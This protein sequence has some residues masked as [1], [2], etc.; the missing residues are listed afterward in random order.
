MADTN[1]LMKY[2]G[3]I[4]EAIATRPQK[5]WTQPMEIENMRLNRDRIGEATKNLDDILKLRETSG[6]SLANAL[7]NIPQQQGYGTWLTDFARAFGGGMAAPMEARAQRA[8]KKH[9]ADL[10]DLLMTLNYDKAMG[11]Y[12]GYDN[13]PYA[14]GRGTGTGEQI[15]PKVYDF[16]DAPLPEKPVSWSELDVQ[17]YNRINPET[18]VRTPM[19]AVL[20]YM[21]ERLNPQGNDAMTANQTAYAEEFTTDR[22]AEVAKATGGNRGIDTMP[23]VTLKGGPELAATNMNSRKFAEAVQNRAWDAADQ[24]IKANPNATITREE[25]ANAFIN[26]FNHKIKPEYR[27]VGLYKAQ[28]KPA[29]EKTEQ[30]AQPAPTA[31]DYSKYGF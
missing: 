16:S 25:L 8:E 19:G 7:A 11:E 13:Y 27:V 23:E 15:K 9:A 4:A 14:G 30:A 22:I 26:N 6:Y 1:D 12:I 31:Y 18:G 24:I 28:T 3:S 10:Q 2:F 17:G 21:N 20:N 29:Q 5:S